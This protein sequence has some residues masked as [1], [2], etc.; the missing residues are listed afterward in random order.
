MEL[1]KTTFSYLLRSRGNHSLSEVNPK[2]Q[3]LFYPKE[4]LFFSIT[5]L[6][7]KNAIKFRKNNRASCR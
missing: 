2:L 4:E 1:L 3:P 5:D 7:Q 6:K